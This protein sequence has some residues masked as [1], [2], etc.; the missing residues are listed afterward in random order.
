M[1]IGTPQAL[2]SRS[3]HQILQ[4]LQQQNSEESAETTAGMA[5]IESLRHRHDGQDA[6]WKAE[7]TDTQDNF[8][9]ARS[10]KFYTVTLPC[11]IWSCMFRPRIV[12]L[13]TAQQQSTVSLTTGLQ[14][15][16]QLYRF[17]RS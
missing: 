13:S 15:S 1:A 5:H 6:L 14:A 2:L 12:L 10:Y 8:A 9:T 7:S 11:W 17:P 16:D 3:P 4:L